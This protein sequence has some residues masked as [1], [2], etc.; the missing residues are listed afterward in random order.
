VSGIAWGHVPTWLAVIVAAV[1]GGIA[2]RQLR[3]QGNVIKGEVER[4]KRRDEL[5][6]GQL[7]ELEQR[8]RIIERQQA[9]A[10]DFSWRTGMGAA[11]GGSGEVE[12]AEVHEA[13]VANLSRRPIRNVTCRIRPLPVQG[14]DWGAVV[15][16]ELGEQPEGFRPAIS[17]EAWFD[18]RRDDKVPLIRA[19]RKFVFQFPIPS[20]SSPD[21]KMKAR[22]TDDAQ[23]HW[24]IDSDLHLEKL[25]E[26]D[27]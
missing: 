20:E 13:V 1:G 19:G 2:L 7:A 15:V 17:S 23:I 5:L 12:R 25:P 21:A 24:Q 26:R 11:H 14:Y 8:G 22:F 18:E 27:W 16:A 3:Q 10:V 6:D 9:D 4:N